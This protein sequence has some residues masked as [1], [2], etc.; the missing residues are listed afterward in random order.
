MRIAYVTETYPPEL[1]GVALTVERTVRWLRERGH[2]VSLVRPRQGK[3]CHAAQ[4]T[5]LTPGLPI[6]MYP[7]LRFGLPIRSRLRRCW[8]RERPDVV[9]AATEGPLGSA[10]VAVARRLGIPVTSDFRTNFQKYGSHYALGWAEPVIRAYLRRFHNRTDLTFAPTNEIVRQLRRYGVARVTEVGRGVDARRFSP[11]RRSAEVR[12]SWGVVDDA[13]AVLYVGRLAAEKNIHLLLRAFAAIKGVN[14]AARLILVG[15]GPMRK[16]LQRSNP[17]VVFTGALGDTTLA[18]AYASADIFLFPSLTETFGNVTLEALASGL[19]VVA[20]DTGAAAQH[21]EHEVNGFLVPVETDS[22]F[23]VTAAVA[24]MRFR[25]R[26]QMRR[27]AREA[28]L[29]A[30]WPTVLAR[31]EAHLQAVIGS[32][33]TGYARSRS[34]TTPSSSAQ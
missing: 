6:P 14:A 31:F 32:R 9:H 19:I 18:A 7:G 29:R 8:Q 2:R 3:E 28:A 5:I 1:N 25:E 21:I 11:S 24:A 10:A 34:S 20:Y 26:Q 30:A 12:E 16:N 33:S 22:Q 15:D 23:V 4:D 27:F 13:P 17:D